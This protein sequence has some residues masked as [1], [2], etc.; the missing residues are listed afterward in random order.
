MDNKS[1]KA[2]VTKAD[3]DFVRVKVFDTG[4]IKNL[5]DLDFTFDINFNEYKTS[6]L[7]HEEKAKI[8]DVLRALDICFPDGREW[9]PAEVFE[10]L[11]DIGLLSGGFKTISWTA[12]DKYFITTT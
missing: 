8:F 11:R 5:L 6:T 2:Y 12:P 1:A 7:K 4:L 10:Y 3:T 9:C